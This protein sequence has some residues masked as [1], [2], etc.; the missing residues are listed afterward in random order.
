MDV[1]A[2]QGVLPVA[3]PGDTLK[4]WKSV[5]WGRSA[6]DVLATVNELRDRG[7]HRLAAGLHG[8]VS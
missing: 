3:Q 7:L 5:R 6:T 2:W 8:L 4:F 1:A